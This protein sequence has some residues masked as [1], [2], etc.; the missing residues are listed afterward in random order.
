MCV[1]SNLFPIGDRAGVPSGV[2]APEAE[3]GSCRSRNP[4]RT[5]SG[6]RGGGALDGAGCWDPPLLPGPPDDDSALRMRISNSPP[7]VDPN[8]GCERDSC[9]TA[10]GIDG[11]RCGVDGGDAD[12]G[13]EFGEKGL[14]GLWLAKLDWVVL[15]MGMAEAE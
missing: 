5:P 3:Y 11:L 8:D 6:V 1:S 4:A 9:T 2:P 12:V 7:S 15:E 14:F 13:R 10:C